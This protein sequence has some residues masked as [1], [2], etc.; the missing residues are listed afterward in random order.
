MLVPRAGAAQACVAVHTFPV[1][2]VCLGSADLSFTLPG[3]R[4]SFLLMS[5]AKC[6]C[7]EGRTCV[8]SELRSVAGK[9]LEYLFCSL[10]TSVIEKF[11]FQEINS[12]FF[13]F[14]FVILSR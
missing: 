6:D 3:T 5:G 11:F 2:I 10:A 4:A 8:A 1:V 7:C 13:F 9:G 14:F 12:L